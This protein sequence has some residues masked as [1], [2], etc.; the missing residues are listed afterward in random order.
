MKKRS[1]KLE[2]LPGKIRNRI[3][4]YIFD[5]QRVEISRYMDETARNH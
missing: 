2:R 5:T 1:A 3:Y 4:S